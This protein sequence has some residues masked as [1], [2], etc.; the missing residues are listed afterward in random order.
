MKHPNA[1]AYSGGHSKV[2]KVCHIGD[3]CPGPNKVTAKSMDDVSMM[4]CF[5][6]T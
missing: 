5:L 1:D 4:V 6:A 2:S 3:G